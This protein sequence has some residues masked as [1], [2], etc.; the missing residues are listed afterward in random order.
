MSLLK[1][2]AKLSAVNELGCRLD[3]ILENASKDLYRAEGAVSALKQAVSALENLLKILD[4]E[5]SDREVD[6]ESC[7]TIKTYFDRA[8]Q[9]ISNLA[10]SSESNR[11]SQVGKIQGFEQAVAVA[12]K[13]KDE[14][15][16]K[17]QVIKNVLDRNSTQV[18]EEPEEE[19]PAEEKKTRPVGT[20]P[21]PSI[22]MRRISEE[23]EKADK[24]SEDVDNLEANTDKSN[25][26]PKKKK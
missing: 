2:E 19:A 18:A 26:R 22:K 23:V 4:K 6:L 11:Q 21:G 13:F 24:V 7:K 5:L 14:E 17:L 10:A 9:T 15:L 1:A 16:N 3:D 8:R 20:R 12:K 25:S